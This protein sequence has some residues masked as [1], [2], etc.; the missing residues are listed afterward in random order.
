MAE[1]CAKAEH[2]IGTQGGGMDQAAIFLAEK[3]YA[4]SIEFNPLRCKNVQ[5][6]AKYSFLIIDSLVKA[7]KAATADFN[8]RVIECRLAAMVLGTKLQMDA[9]KYQNLAHIQKAT[10]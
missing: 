7:N 3:N 5:L 10:K 1:I 2:H 8:T 4:Q 6:P 9:D